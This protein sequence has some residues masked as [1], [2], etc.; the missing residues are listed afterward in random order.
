MARCWHRDKP[1]RYRN[2]RGHCNRTRRKKPNKGLCIYDYYEILE[3]GMKDGKPEKFEFYRLSV[4][5]S[6]EIMS[7]RRKK[8]DK[9][10]Q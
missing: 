1:C 7:D 2:H 8:V 4:K 3:T 5:I 9:K 6:I 10:L